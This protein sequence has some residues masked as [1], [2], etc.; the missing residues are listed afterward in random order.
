M[1]DLIKKILKEDTDWDWVN[2]TNPVSKE[3]IHKKLQ[4]LSS[5]GYQL[6]G[7]DKLIDF[8][9]KLALDEKSLKLFSNILD[10][11]VETCYSTGSDRLS[12]DFWW[13]G[14]REGYREGYGEEEDNLRDEIQYQYDEGYELGESEGYEEGYKK[15]Y[16][17]GVEVTYHKAF[18]EG[19]AY[20]A[21]IDV[22]D[23]ERRESGFDPR[24]YDEDYDENY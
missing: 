19:R 8:L 21:G 7:D 6:M 15:G 5:Y 10:N 22:E 2:D 20:E 1:K 18:E 4:F 23:L 3:D 24:D 16:E 11:I 13:E 9:Y 17:E 12:Q 14:H